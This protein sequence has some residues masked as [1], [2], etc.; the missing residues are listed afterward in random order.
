MDPKYEFFIKV[1][2]SVIAAVSLFFTVRN[3]VRRSRQALKLDLEIL[4]LL[5]NPTLRTMV[6]DRVR[7]R[8]RRLYGTPVEG[9]GVKRVYNPGMLVFGCVT[10]VGFAAWTIYLNWNHAG[11]NWWS[12]LTGF[13]ALGGFGNIVTALQPPRKLEG[14]AAA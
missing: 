8:I 2:S 13:F 12:L 14:E 6:E 5:K 10:L 11:F 7:T 1:V 4:E 3:Q 9:E